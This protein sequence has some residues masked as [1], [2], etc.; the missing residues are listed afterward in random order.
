MSVKVGVSR[1]YYHVSE[2]LCDT[3][4]VIFRD[5]DIIATVFSRDFTVLIKSRE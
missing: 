3:Y 1:N 5:M 2:K 4:F